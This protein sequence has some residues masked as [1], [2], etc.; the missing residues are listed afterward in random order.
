MIEV[1]TDR[2]HGHPFTENAARFTARTYDSA[3]TFLDA[4]PEVETGCVITDVRM[5]EINGIELLRPSQISQD[6]L[7][8]DCHLGTADVPLAIGRGESPQRLSL[9][10][11]R[12]ISRACPLIG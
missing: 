10:V 5:P 2:S 3:R 7:A 9:R 4:V 1:L 6:R 8:S 11:W 12:A